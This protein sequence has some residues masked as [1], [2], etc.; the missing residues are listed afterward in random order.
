MNKTAITFVTLALIGAPAMGKEIFFGKSPITLKIRPGE[1]TLLFFPAPVQT[2]SGAKHFRVYPTDKNS[3]NYKRLSVE[4]RLRSGKKKVL[5]VLADGAI[6]EANLEI[7]KDGPPLYQIHSKK[8]HVERPEAAKTM[9]SP[10]ELMKAMIQGKR[11]PGF[12][13]KATETPIQLSGSNVKGTLSQVYEGNRYA[14]YVIKLE[15]QTRFKSWIVDIA[16]LSVNSDAKLL[17]SHIEP[18]TIGPRGNSASKAT[19]RIVTERQLRPESNVLPFEEFE[20]K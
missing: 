12:K 19:L 6:I 3:P 16:R 10:M 8:K 15:N 2:I 14:G 17:L 5:F 9:T 13:R 4:P 7:S 18:Q 1:A 20:R 11:H